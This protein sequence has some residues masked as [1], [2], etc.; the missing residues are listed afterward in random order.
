M[1]C[2]S[3][4]NPVETRFCTQCGAD[5]TTPVVQQPTHQPT[6]WDRLGNAI[7]LTAQ[8]QAALNAMNV[9]Q[10]QQNGVNRNPDGSWSY[11]N[12][13]SGNSI[14]SDGTSIDFTR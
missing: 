10:Q 5:Q 13:Y 8:Q 2:K 1:Y 7:I 6:F 14:I 3:C 12:D 11:R 4:G 9:Q